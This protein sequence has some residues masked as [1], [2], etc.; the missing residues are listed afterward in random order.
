VEWIREKEEGSESTKW[1]YATNGAFFKSNV[2]P[3]FF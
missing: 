2:A 1:D 3:P